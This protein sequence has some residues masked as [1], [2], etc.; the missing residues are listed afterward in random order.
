MIPPALIGPTV[1]AALRFGA[2]R[3]AVA[4]IPPEVL[5]LIKRGESHVDEIVEMESR[6]HT[7]VR[8][9]SHWV[10]AHLEPSPAQQAAIRR[11]RS[12]TRRPPR[13]A[14]DAL[15]ARHVG[16]LKRIGLA[17]V[18]YQSAEGHFPPAAITSK[19][20]KPLLS[21]RVAILPYLENFD[22]D[23]MGDLHKAFHLDEPWDSPHNMALLARM[24]AV[25]AAP[26]DPPRATPSTTHYR[27]FVSTQGPQPA[28]RPHAGMN[29]CE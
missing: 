25:F 28:G 18:N 1:E 23:T 5:P 24:P 14:Q 17:M 3:F 9:V 2:S 26:E 16:N 19:D 22:G 21:W 12:P 27:G 13:R 7:G 29:R 4:M 8:S 6:G 15:W 11:R 10:R 20:G